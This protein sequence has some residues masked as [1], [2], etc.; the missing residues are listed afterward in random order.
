MCLSIYPGIHGYLQLSVLPCN[1]THLPVQQLLAPL[2]FVL[3]LQLCVR[4]GEPVVDHVFRETFFGYLQQ[5]RG[6]DTRSLAGFERPGYV[7]VCIYIDCYMYIKTDRGQLY[8]VVYL[9]RRSR[10]LGRIL[11]QLL[12]NNARHPGRHDTVKTGQG[13]GTDAVERRRREQMGIR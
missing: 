10:P 13:T 2:F 12:Q 8:I 11:Q 5:L 7:D 9:P 6:L 1:Q 3:V 4:K